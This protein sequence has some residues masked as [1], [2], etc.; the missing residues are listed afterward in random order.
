[1]Y[2]GMKNDIQMKYFSDNSTLRYKITGGVKKISVLDQ[3]GEQMDT[4]EDGIKGF[5]NIAIKK[6]L[7]EKEAT[8]DSWLD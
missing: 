3:E 2:I 1:M 7:K 8:I 6:M 4:E 5:A